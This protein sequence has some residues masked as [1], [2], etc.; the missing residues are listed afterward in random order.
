MFYVTTQSRSVRLN[1]DT[2]FLKLI[3]IASMLVDHIGAALLPQYGGLRIAGRLAFPIFAYCL[4]VGAVYTRSVPKY[5]QRLLIM[6]LVSQPLY[7]LALNHA[8]FPIAQVDSA[9]A[10]LRWYVD[11]L[12]T[13]NIMF[14]LLLGLLTIWSIKERKYLFTAFMVAV[15]WHVG[16][17]F[18]MTSYGWNGV[19]LMVLFYVF[20]DQPLTSFVWVAAFMAWWGLSYTLPI[21]GQSFNVT[22]STQFWAVLALPLIYLPMNTRIK[23]NK[24]VF[25][26][27][28]PAHLAALYAFKFLMPFMAHWD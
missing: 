18:L 11:S 2:D 12:R 13:S 17:H 20:I 5:A 7:V 21:G 22:V 25:Y 23:L 14:E 19:L 28:Y 1:Q 4:A 9:A 8:P 10:A 3:A 24:W 26:L 16:P 6:A 27:F 15:V